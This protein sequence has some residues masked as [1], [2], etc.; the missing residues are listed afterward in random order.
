MHKP[1]CYDKNEQTVSLCNQDFRV[2]HYTPRMPSSEREQKKR[3]VGRR[4]YQAIHRND[5]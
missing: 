4:L 3:L 2:I 5:W 1:C